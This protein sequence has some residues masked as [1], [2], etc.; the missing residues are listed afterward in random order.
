MSPRTYS[1]LGFE[2]LF[3]VNEKKKYLIQIV[4]LRLHKKVKNNWQLLIQRY[5][6]AKGQKFL[7][8]KTVVIKH[9]DTADKC[10]KRATKFFV[11]KD[12]ARKVVIKEK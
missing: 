11:K 10:L 6:Q 7:A 5:R 8:A 1:L 12:L 3:V 9:Y 2:N 4:R